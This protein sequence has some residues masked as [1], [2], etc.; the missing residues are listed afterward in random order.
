MIKLNWLIYGAESV[1][2]M[3]LTKEAVRRKLTPVLAGF[4]GQ[5]IFDFASQIGLESRIINLDVPQQATNLLKDIEVVIVCC[6]LKAKLQH[7]LLKLCLKLGIHYCDTSS[8]LFSYERAQK[9]GPA[10]ADKNLCLLLGMHRSVILGD[11]VAAQLKR[12]IPNS[13]TLVIAI[14]E[15]YSSFQS[16]IDVLASGG[17]VIRNNRLKRPS[18]PQ[19][20]LV[21][22]KDAPSL[23]VTFPMAVLLSAWVSTRIPNIKVFRSSMPEEIRF[24]RIFRFVR[25]L[26]F[27]PYLAR[28]LCRQENFLI[29]HF[30]IKPYY[31]RKLSVWGRAT[32]D[33]NTT[34]T[35]QLEVTENT[36]LATSLIFRCLEALSLQQVPAGVL[37]PS[38]L[39]DLEYWTEK[40]ACVRVAD[41]EVL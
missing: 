14:S 2:G 19:S 15:S 32:A 24:L 23:T 10:F 3:Q 11:L 6:E 31:T 33:Q 37:T 26:F 12:F 8:D 27:L 9:Y 28:W 17:R 20:L 5:E 39:A 22:F 16:I 34:K 25:W 4:H 35:M 40:E 29:K 1:T 30:A 36:D 21:C 18:A 38:Q 13:K 7:S 41:T